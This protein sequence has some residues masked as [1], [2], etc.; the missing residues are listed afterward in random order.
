MTKTNAYSKAAKKRW[1]DHEY[2]K[3]RAE[4]MSKV[5]RS[6]EWKQNHADAMKNLCKDPTWLAAQKRAGI[7]RFRDPNWWKSVEVSAK[8]RGHP[9]RATHLKTGKTHQFWG[10]KECAR[11]MSSMYGEKFNDGCISLVCN[12]NAPHHKG[13]RFQRIKSL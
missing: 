12:G 10:M 1:Q 4:A 6:A 3:M 11:Q 9:V 5:V 2:R 8:K 13:W 7:K